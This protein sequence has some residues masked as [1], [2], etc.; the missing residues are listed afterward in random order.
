MH[1]ESMVQRGKEKDEKAR[2]KEELTL[3]Q[4]VLVSRAGMAGRRRNGPRRARRRRHG[5]GRER[6]PRLRKRAPLVN[7]SGAGEEGSTAHILAVSASPGVVGGD[8]DHDG[9]ERRTGSSFG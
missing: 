9:G 1:G 2:K 4:L 6:R 8:G 3:E 7:C 5:G